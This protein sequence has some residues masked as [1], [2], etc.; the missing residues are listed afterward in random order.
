[1]NK[2]YVDSDGNYIGSFEG[3]KPPSGS[4][5]IE[6]P[7]NDARQ[8]WDGS[9]FLPFDDIQGQIEALESSVTPRN[10]RDFIMGNQYSIDKINKVESDIAIL[11]AKL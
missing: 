9:K 3:A 5:E 11:R 7:P 6:T 2:Y 4:I 1:M 8:K 10:Y